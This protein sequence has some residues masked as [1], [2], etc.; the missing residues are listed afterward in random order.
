[1]GVQCSDEFSCV[2]KMG[3]SQGCRMGARVPA[4]AAVDGP[5][6][7]EAG[8]FLTKADAEDAQSASAAKAVDC[9]I[10]EL[11][12]ALRPG[13]AQAPSMVQRRPKT[14]SVTL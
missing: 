6:V 14:R 8:V 3:R 4:G 2:A 10:E 13:T 7:T 5:D 1:M 9:R 11:P 12:I